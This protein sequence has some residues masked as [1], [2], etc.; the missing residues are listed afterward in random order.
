[1]DGINISKKKKLLKQLK[2]QSSKVHT[3]RQWAMRLKIY[4]QEYA[5]P[6]QK[7]FISSMNFFFSCWWYRFSI[8]N[9][10]QEIF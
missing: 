8:T 4:R 7:N 5:C 9:R 1:M 6:E 3:V 2:K 10:T